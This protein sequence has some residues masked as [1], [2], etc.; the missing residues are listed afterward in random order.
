MPKLRGYQLD[1]CVKCNLVDVAFFERN[2]G[3]SDLPMSSIQW[4]FADAIEVRFKAYG[5]G[6]M[7]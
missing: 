1:Y 7:S 6:S 4:G 2:P 3:K 5:L